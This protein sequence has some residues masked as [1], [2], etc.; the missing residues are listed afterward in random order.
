M[1]SWHSNLTLIDG[2]LNF[3]IHNC[4]CEIDFEWQASINKCDVD[5]EAQ[6]R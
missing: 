1:S 4:E 6:T 5:F 3:N 2:L